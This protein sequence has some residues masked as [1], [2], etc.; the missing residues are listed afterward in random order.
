MSLDSYWLH[1]TLELT[2]ENDPFTGMLVHIHKTTQ[3]E[4]I[5]QPIRL[6]T[7]ISLC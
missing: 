1:E 4:G 5:I 2:A 7:T 3:A 6:G